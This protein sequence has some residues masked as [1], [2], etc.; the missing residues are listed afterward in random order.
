MLPLA[1]FSILA[2]SYIVFKF[3]LPHF[4][5]LHR[6][7]G[8]L[9]YIKAITIGAIFLC[10]AYLLEAYFSIVSRIGLYIPKLSIDIFNNKYTEENFIF[11][12]IPLL[13]A[14]IYCLGGYCYL[15]L[16]GYWKS[17]KEKNE[18][19]LSYWER[20]KIL[21][22]YKLLKDSPLDRLLFLS[23]AGE[24]FLIITMTDRKVYVGRINSLGEPT[25]NRGADQE[26][27]IVPIFSG[28]R[29]KD[30]LGVILI[31]DYSKVNNDYDLS[32]ILKQ[33][34]ILSAAEFV[35]DVHYKVTNH[36]L[37]L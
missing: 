16:K 27:S 10:I 14:L 11:F 8:Q 37:V 5:K 15:P 3:S 30:N 6:Y 26:I 9:L 35:E 18:S 36:R 29:D 12:A 19:K 17:R 2:S 20:G 13:L 32:I 25:E 4:Y 7:G 31:T 33:D 23:Y 1:L 21:L 28:Y 22:M 34:N 24:R